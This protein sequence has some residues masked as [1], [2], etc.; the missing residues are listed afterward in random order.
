[1]QNDL[2]K[3]V[4]V[5]QR[6]DMA[7]KQRM[8][9]AIVARPHFGGDGRDRVH[10]QWCVAGILVF[11]IDSFDRPAR[12]MADQGFLP[13][14]ENVHAEMSGLQQERVHA[15]CLAHGHDAQWRFERP[16]HKSIGRQAADFAAHLRGDDR[17]AGHERRTRGG[18]GFGRRRRPQRRGMLQVLSSEDDMGAVGRGKECRPLIRDLQC[19][20]STSLP[21]ATSACL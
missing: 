14:G 10:E 21:S 4:A 1:M 6:E 5:A 16:G 11:R 13:T 3:P 18:R 15:R 12:E 17:Y 2:G 7:D 9:A 20:L 19:A 8:V